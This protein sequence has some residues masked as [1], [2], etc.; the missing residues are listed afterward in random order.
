M[1][2]CAQL[3]AVITALGGCIN[4]CA[5]ASISG[6]ADPPDRIRATRRQPRSDGALRRRS[7]ECR[8]RAAHVRRE[9]AGCEQ[10]DRPCECRACGAGRLHVRHGR[11]K[12]RDRGDDDAQ[13]ALRSGARFRGREPHRDTAPAAGRA[14]FAA[15][16]KREGPHCARQGASGGVELRLLGQRLGIAPG[17]RALQPDGRRAH[18]AHSVQRRWPG[19]YRFAGRAGA[20]EIRQS[21]HVA[22]ARARGEAAPAGGDDPGPHRAHARSCRRSAK[23]CPVFR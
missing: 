16:E 14:R 18:H 2:P 23:R 7:S 6:P 5:G 4:R 19:H 3:V 22:R 9:P 21:L 12:R 13:S 20:D 10:H 8:P 15:G 1:K 11:A 17:A